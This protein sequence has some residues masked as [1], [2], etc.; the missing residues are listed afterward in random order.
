MSKKFEHF[1]SQFRI[2]CR[3]IIII[4]YKYEVFIFVFYFL[5]LKLVYMYP[6][7]FDVVTL[8]GIV[9]LLYTHY[10]AG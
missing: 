9:H 2:S 3:F 4:V 5:H 1:E 10:I 8:I 7:D 6:F